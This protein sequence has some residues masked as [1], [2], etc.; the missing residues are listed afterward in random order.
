M[1]SIKISLIIAPVRLSYAVD[2]PD[3]RSRRQHRMWVLYPVYLVVLIISEVG[4]QRKPVV[5]S[6]LLCS[7]PF[8]VS[9]RRAD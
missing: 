6:L 8:V 1:N 7:L 5:H 2:D 3:V 9:H 4:Y